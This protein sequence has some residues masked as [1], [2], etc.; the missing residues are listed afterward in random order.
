MGQIRARLSLLQ[1]SEAQELAASLIREEPQNYEGY[2]W[3]GFVELQRGSWYAAV[4]HLRQAEKLHPLGT[5]C[6]KYWGLHT[7][8]SGRTFCFS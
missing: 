8:N 6:K 4:R 2:F 1:L 3:T 7:W 5:P